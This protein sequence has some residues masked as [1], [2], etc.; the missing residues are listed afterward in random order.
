MKIKGEVGDDREKRNDRSAEGGRHRTRRAIEHDSRHCTLP[1]AIA[2]L[3]N[4]KRR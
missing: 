4:K 1:R 3:H 2:S